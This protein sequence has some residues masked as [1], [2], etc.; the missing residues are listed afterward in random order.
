MGAVAIRFTQGGNVG[1]AGVCLL[2]EANA[3]VVYENTDNANVS[4]FAWAMHDVPPGSAVAEGALASGAGVSAGTF[5][6]DLPGSYLVGLVATLD[7][8]TRKK[9]ALSFVVPEPNGLVLPPFGANA[10]NFNLG[11][12]KG[13]ASAQRRW[14]KA[15]GGGRRYDLLAGI[16]TTAFEA[17]T[18]MAVGGRR[19]TPRDVVADADPATR[20]IVVSA[21]LETSDGDVAAYFD[22]YDLTAGAAVAGSELFTLAT[23]ATLVTAD[24]SAA[25][26]AIT[27]AHVLEGRIWTAVAGT[28][29]TCRA[30]YVDLVVT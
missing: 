21:L 12:G 10:T 22:L 17:T 7:D 6:P 16:R 1:A 20:T 5:T 14:L 15:G 25:L 18:K 19:F 9:G 28:L 29:A 4:S 30:A 27:T 13:W 23:S 2:G 8:G 26:G 11:D 3:V 24:L